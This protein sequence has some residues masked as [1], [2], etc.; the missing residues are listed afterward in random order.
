MVSRG[1]RNGRRAISQVALSLLLSRFTRSLS[2]NARRTPSRPLRHSLLSD[3]FVLLGGPSWITVAPAQ[4]VHLLGSY[5]GQEACPTLR[6][7]GRAFRG[8]EVIALEARECGRPYVSQ[9][10]SEAARI[11]LGI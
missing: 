11:V 6:V 10:V 3:L 9:C 1:G 2:L 5:L 8:K 4:L 7:V